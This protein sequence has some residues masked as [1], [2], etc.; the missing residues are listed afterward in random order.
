MTTNNNLCIY[1]LLFW[2][3]Q[4]VKTI[5]STVNKRSIEPLHV[6]APW[7]GEQHLIGQNG[8]GE[9][10]DGT[11]CNRQGECTQPQPG[12][13]RRKKRQAISKVTSVCVK[14]QASIPA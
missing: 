7:E 3:C 14:P 1:Q 12:R 2:F 10:E 6:V 8:D 13:R 5:G 4:L 9:K 11:D